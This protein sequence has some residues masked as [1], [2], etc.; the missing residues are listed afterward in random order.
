MVKLAISIKTEQTS[1]PSNLQYQKIQR[2]SHTILVI[3]YKITRDWHVGN[4]AMQIR[5]VNREEPFRRR[6]FL[7][8]LVMTKL[9]LLCLIIIQLEANSY[10]SIIVSLMYIHFS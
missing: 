10:T 2:K 8:F 9:H 5:K 3:N 7:F 4:N 6:I 1:P